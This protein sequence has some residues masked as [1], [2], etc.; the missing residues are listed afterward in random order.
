[1][2]LIKRESDIFGLLF[3]GDGVNIS[4]IPQL[5]I[6][7]NNRTWRQVAA[8]TFLEKVG[9]NPLGTY[10]DRRQATVLEWVAL[11]PILEVSARDTG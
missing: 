7:V 5:K 2:S 11:R 6:F 1:M 9:Y 10:I 8:D 3:L 4:R